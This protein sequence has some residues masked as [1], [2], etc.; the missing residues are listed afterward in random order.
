[1]NV[2]LTSELAVRLVDCGDAIGKD[3][4]RIEL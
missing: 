1:M 2:S 4:G 3:R